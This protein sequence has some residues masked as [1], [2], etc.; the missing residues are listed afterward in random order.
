MKID[1][2]TKKKFVEA[3]YLTMDNVHRYRVILRIA[4]NEYEKMKFWLYK[5]EIFNKIKYVD[6]FEDYTLDYLKQD[7]DALEGWKNFITIQDTNK[8]KTLEEFKNRKFK[9]QISPNT[10]EL[11]RMLIKL[12]SMKETSRGSLEISLIERFGSTLGEIKTLLN[13]DDKEIFTWWDTLNRDFKSLNENYQ[14]YISKFYSPKTEQL[15]KTTEFLIFKESFIR[16]LR[17]FVKGIQINVPSIQN[18][19]CNI[20]HDEITFLIKKFLDYE[21]INIALDSEFN[22]EE[23]FDIHYGRYINMKQWFLG[24]GNN[25]SMIDNLLDN[26]N[27]I[28]RQITRYALQIVDM[29][30]SGGS[31]K[32]DFKTLINIF[33]NCENIDEAHKLSSVVFGVISSRHVVA[34]I[35]RETESINSSIFDENPTVLTIKPSNR[36]REKTAS[37]VHVIDKSREKKEKAKAVLREREMEQ[38]I[39]ESRIKDNK[40]L[41]RN[42]NGITQKERSVFLRWL[43]IGLNK[44]HNQWCRNE[45]GRYYKVNTPHDEDVICIK[46][47]DGDLYMPAYE[48]I[49][50]EDE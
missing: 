12:E 2:I 23:E 8:T 42:L 20:K 37:R 29:Q 25:S 44:K 14:D 50:K 16:Y 30:T 22:K 40:L 39:L 36:Y 31:R 9:Y 33:N 13:S 28:I 27:D 24:S 17:D 26:T 18:T 47:K 5:E 48:F 45:F 32:E 43:S 6:G 7:L 41:F 35:D 49:F 38:K 1:L 3:T 4:Y 34:N 19:F 11:E 10:I 15:L 46:C 21:Q